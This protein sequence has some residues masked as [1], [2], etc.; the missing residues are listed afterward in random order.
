MQQNPST[1][2]IVFGAF[3]NDEHAARGDGTSSAS[4]SCDNGLQSVLDKNRVLTDR[5]DNNSNF[6]TS[7][8]QPE[9]CH[10]DLNQNQQQSIYLR[11]I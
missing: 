11:I 1:T 10:N 2:E 8:S 9:L 7:H 5:V 6:I 4:G 3:R